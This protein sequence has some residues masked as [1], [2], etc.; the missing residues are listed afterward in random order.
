MK[1]VLLA[2]V[3]LL[4]MS[5]AG[6]AADLIR[7]SPPAQ[8]VY[9]APPP[10]SWT[11]LYLGLNAGYGFGSYN[12]AGTKL[13]GDSNGFIGGGQLGYNYQLQNNVVLGVESDLQF[14]DMKANGRLGSGIPV[15]SRASLDL[16]GSIRGRLGYAFNGTGSMLDRSMIYVTGGY[17]YG[18]NDVSIPGLGSNTQFHS[19]FAVGGGIEYAFT[20]NW[21][22]R[23]EGMYVSLGRE[24][25]V[26]NN[27]ATAKAGTDF[28]LVRAA[29][30][31]KF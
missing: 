17:A 20:N 23:L 9:Y 12:N 10:F 16:F 30:N 25:Y 19:G 2:G 18:N 22:A 5:A 26:F 21:S 1:R 11:G 14:A 13:F 15:A 31:Y 6:S 24:R 7:K 28:G 29:I 4:S 27:G 3:A 8:P